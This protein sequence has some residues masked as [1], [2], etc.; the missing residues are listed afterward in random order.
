MTRHQR[1]YIFEAFN[2]FHVRYY[3]NEI[4][5]GKPVRKQR[6]HRLCSKDRATGHGTPSAKAVRQACDEF[7]LKVNQTQHTSQS[8]QQDILI[9][10][11]WQQRYL[12]YNEEI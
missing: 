7:M 4:V 11:F 5:D 12:P 2:A 1:G 3:A 10:D 8:L 9:S 6:S